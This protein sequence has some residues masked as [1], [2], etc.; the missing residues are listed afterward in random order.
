V[1]T[2]SGRVLPK[3][4]ERLTETHWVSNANNRLKLV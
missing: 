4:L 1:M 3:L 2:Q